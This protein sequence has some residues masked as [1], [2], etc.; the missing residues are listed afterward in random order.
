MTRQQLLEGDLLRTQ[1]HFGGRWRDG[2]GGERRPV[3]DPATGEEIVSVAVATAD[4][5]TEAIDAAAEAFATWSKVP[6]P[7]RSRILRRWY[8]LVVEHV[9][10]LAEILTWEQGKPLAEARGEILYGAGFIE[11]FAEEAKRLYGEVIPTNN[12]NR[13]MLTTRNPVG[14]TA[15]ITPW[16]FPSAMILR[17]A[18]PALAAGCTMIIKPAGETPLSA[19]AL[20]A[21]AERAGVPAGV[22][23]VVNGSGAEIGA[24]LTAS[25]VVRTISFTGSTEVGRTLMAQSADTLK[26]LALE[27]GGN[28][29]LIVFDDADLDTAVKGAMDSKF[30]NAGQTCVCANRILVQDGIHDAFVEAFTKAVAALRV[31]DGREP[32]VTQGPLISQSALAKVRSHIDDAVQ[33]G[34]TVAHG[35]DVTEQG[36]TFFTPTVL[37]GATP[38]MLIA[39]EETFGPVA[40]IFRFSTEAE[41]I[42]LANDTEFGL[43]GY[44][45]SRDI[46]RVTRVAEAL[47]VGVVGVNTGLISYEGAPFG[48][49]KQ[50]GIGREGSLH[51]I[52]EYTEMKY[53]CI[54]G[55]A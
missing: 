53:I 49:V 10:E 4:D 2:S 6:A 19:F 12:P 18:S 38:S 17:K 37:V 31:G 15:A 35:G 34:A 30:R 26:H 1:L 14:V 16:N 22:L 11:W 23:S 20:V 52:D 48:G 51:G 9:D 32:G 7:E 3:T 5:V 27:L 42:A 36:G 39:S 45:F 43:A 44:F 54:E 13:R 33:H 28:A 40:P 50:S 41:A 24:V 55:V 25:E 8:D 29:P 47:E 46:G 21:L